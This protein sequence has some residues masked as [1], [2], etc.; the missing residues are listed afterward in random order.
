MPKNVQTSA[1]LHSFH[2]LVR[3]YSKILQ[4]K[5]HQYM[6]QELPDV[7][8]GFEETEKPEVKFP[9][10]LDN[11][12]SKGIPEKKFASLTLQKPLTV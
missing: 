2:M 5:I 6:N 4:A 9:T 11:R 8:L 7:H 3:L 12:Q 1:Q 10:S